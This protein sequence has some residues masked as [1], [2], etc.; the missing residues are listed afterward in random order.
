MV[1]VGLDATHQVQLTEEQFQKYKGSPF[2]DGVHH[3]LRY[4]QQKYIQ[5][6]QKDYVP[7]HDDFTLYYL[8]DSSDFLG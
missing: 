8:L 4:Y 2:K 1:M 5:V 7:C 3:Q 6:N